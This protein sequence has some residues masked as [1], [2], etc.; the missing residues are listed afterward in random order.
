MNRSRYSE[1]RRNS[2]V[3]RNDPPA[4]HGVSHDAGYVGIIEPWL[5]IFV[6]VSSCSQ[7]KGSP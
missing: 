3:R 5:G 1:R 4:S 2:A 6:W 7:W